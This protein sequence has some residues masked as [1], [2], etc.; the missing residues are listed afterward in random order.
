MTSVVVIVGFVLYHLSGFAVGPVCALSLPLQVPESRFFPANPL[1]NDTLTPLRTPIITAPAPPPG[2]STRI[3]YFEQ[4]PLNP[5]EIFIVAIQSM[6]LLAEQP[7][8]AFVQF[9][10]LVISGPKRLELTVEILRQ[11]LQYKHIVAA[12]YEVGVK[13]ASES[14]YYR[15]LATLDVG[16]VEGGNLTFQP[17]TLGAHDENRS[18]HHVALAERIP[19]SLSNLTVGADDSASIIDPTDSKFK[20]EYCFDG[21]RIT[22]AEIF[23][24]FLDALAYAAEQDSDAVDA[25]VNGVSASGHCTI[26]MHALA[27]RELR[28]KQLVRAL[29]IL[30]EDV[31]MGGVQ[32]KGNGA[33]FEGL[34][35]GLLYDGVRIGKGF[36]WKLPSVS[37]GEGGTAWG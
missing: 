26:N 2:L 25:Y 1:R 6:T 33:R 9:T 34:E 13:I 28:W 27:G 21:V 17:V 5:V 32:Q 23:T 3:E 30:W 18:T 24:T 14:K 20:L 11:I 7:Y 15:C 10:D 36:L 19:A 37:G 4:T 16:G 35:F 8:D 22:A 12:L 31:I 29:L